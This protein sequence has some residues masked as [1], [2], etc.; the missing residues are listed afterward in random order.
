MQ[1][2]AT[3][4]NVVVVNVSQLRSNAIIVSLTSI[5]TIRLPNLSAAN[6]KI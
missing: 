4:S 3:N 2:C 5:R 6:A 1:A